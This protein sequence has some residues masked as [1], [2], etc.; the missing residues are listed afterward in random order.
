MGNHRTKWGW[1]IK[2]SEWCTIQTYLRFIV[3]LPSAMIQVAAEAYLQLAFHLWGFG[4][5][6]PSISVLAIQLWGVTW[7]APEA[8]GCGKPNPINNNQNWIHLG[9]VHVKI[10]DSEIVHCWVYHSLPHQRLWKYQTKHQLQ[11]YGPMGWDPHSPSERK[12]QNSTHHHFLTMQIARSHTL[13]CY[14]RG[15]SQWEDG[16]VHPHTGF[17]SHYIS[18]YTVPSGK[19]LHNYGKIHHF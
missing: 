9:M 5:F 10:G 12:G 19:R 16:F 14:L 6:A 17:F 1:L 2:L 3:F 4:E 15:A 13:F 11:S 18:W 8:L 7:L